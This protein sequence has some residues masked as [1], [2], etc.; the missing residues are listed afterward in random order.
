MPPLLFFYLAKRVATAALVVEAGLCIPVILTSLFHDLPPAAIRGGLLLP[1]LFGTVPTV[2]YVA[3][4]MALGIGVAIEFTRMS[5]DGMIA[6]LYSLRLSVWAIS[7]PTVFVA[8]AAV[9]FGYWLSSF[10][11]PA[12][13]GEMHDVIYVIRNSLNHRMLEPA[14]FYNFDNGTKTLY[15]RRWQ[16]TDVVSGIFIYQF[17][18]EKNEEQ[19]ITAQQAE[20][21]RNETSVVLILSHG[22]IET[23]SADGQSIQTAHFDQYAMPI[24]MQGSG[25]LP[26]RSW[27]GV[28]EMGF[29]EFFHARPSPVIFPRLYGEWMSEAAKRCGIPLLALTHAL[30]AIGLV[31]SLTSISGRSKGASAVTVLTIPVIHVAILVSAETMVRH[32]PWMIV[33][34]GLA[35]LAELMAGLWLIARQNADFPQSRTAKAVAPSPA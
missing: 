23:V 29:L 27:R 5:T 33:L 32:N 1:A 10:F 11:A 22:A 4:P 16:S 17:S 18:A 14:E 19:V 8:L 7:L 28:F 12:H 24:G 25:G 21:R 35:I 31:L 34:V 26:Q 6:V 9:V 13:V 30:F 2:L 3:L 20:F 15:F